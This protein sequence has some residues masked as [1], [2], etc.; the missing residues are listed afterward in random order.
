MKKKRVRFRVDDTNLAKEVVDS[1][2]EVVVF[3][4]RKKESYT[5]KACEILEWVKYIEITGAD[6]VESLIQIAKDI[7]SGR[8]MRSYRDNEIL[9]KK[10]GYYTYSGNFMVT[11]NAYQLYNS[12]PDE[13]NVQLASK[14]L[15]SLY[16]GQPDWRCKKSIDISKLEEVQTLRLGPMYENV[17]FNKKGLKVKKEL[18]LNATFDA[19]QKDKYFL[20]NPNSYVG[21]FSLGFSQ[22]NRVDYVK[23]LNIQAR[24]RKIKGIWGV[25]FIDTLILNCSELKE[26]HHTGGLNYC[27]INSIVMNN[28]TGL[29]LVVRKVME[30]CL[31]SS[32]NYDKVEQ[33]IKKLFRKGILSVETINRMADTLGFPILY[34][35]VTGF[36]E[37]SMFHQAEKVNMNGKI[38]FKLDS[39][40][41]L[42]KLNPEYT[43]IYSSLRE[44]I[45]ELVLV[46][47]RGLQI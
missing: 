12:T 45:R 34:V 22:K 14:R 7:E 39:Y 28:V 40:E 27:Y 43:N 17:H 33:D 35:D 21:V 41:W 1:N 38:Y 18:S 26:I 30:S 3:D 19:I 10:N 47:K 5:V 8:V 2:S 11:I 36:A 25:G 46:H 13:I 16:I 31:V 24:I 37:Y 29:E 6:E 42:C 4:K 44:R 23:D 15:Q 9:I 20:G 32:V